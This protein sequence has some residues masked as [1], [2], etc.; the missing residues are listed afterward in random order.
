[1]KAK[2]LVVA[3]ALL[4]LAALY[5]VLVYVPTDK[6]S[7]IVQR[8]FYFHVPLAWVAFLAFFI[9]FIFSILYLWQRAQKW[10]FVA[11]AAAEVGLVFT[12]LVLIT[13]SIWARPMWGVWWTWDARLTT[14]L[15]LWLIYVAYFIIRAYVGESGRQ[16]RFGAVV[17]IVGFVDVPIV[18]MAITLA[19]TQHPPPLIFEGGLAPS[20]LLTLLVSLV[21]FTALF[22]SILMERVALKSSEG[23]LKRLKG[24]VRR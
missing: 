13:G 16:A 17:G 3:S 6:E 22:F 20:M 18:A 19:R 9:V 4:M 7:G 23:E 11:S 14:A 12:T 21:A 2:I 15:I 5:M 1:M 24:L 8:I 10:D